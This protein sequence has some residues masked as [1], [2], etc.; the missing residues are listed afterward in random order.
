M[1]LPIGLPIGLPVGWA[2]APRAARMAPAR[3]RKVERFRLISEETFYLWG[4]C[5]LL[6]RAWERVAGRM[7]RAAS[8]R[9]NGKRPGSDE[10]TDRAARRLK[11]EAQAATPDQGHLHREAQDEIGRQQHAGETQ[12]ESEQNLERKI[13]ERTAQLEAFQYLVEGV[14][15]YALFMLD[16]QGVITNWNTGAERIKGYRASEIVG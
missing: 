8:N 10:A 5:T 9:K 4:R 14:R 7:A 11:E 1:R 2:R 3:P 6:G 16:T 15:D 13:Q 12:R